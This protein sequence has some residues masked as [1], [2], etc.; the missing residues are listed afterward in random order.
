M[1]SLSVITMLLGRI[2]LAALFAAGAVQK[3]VSPT[4]AQ[5]LL[6]AQ[7]WPTLLVWPAL[8]LNALGAISLGTG[9]LITPMAL[10][11]ALY[12]MVTSLF[13]FI[14][15]DPWQMS[16]FVKNWAIS[17]GLLVLFAHQLDRARE[18]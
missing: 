10:V 11:L 3:F 13:H 7:G 12:C 8:A 17:G 6:A 18:K 15:H 14:P 2:L 4:G 5:T 1:N 9:I 16:I